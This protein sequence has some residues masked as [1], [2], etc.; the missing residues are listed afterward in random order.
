MAAKDSHGVVVVWVP[1]K[2]IHR[3]ESGD[4]I[5]TMKAEGWELF[6]NR[7]VAEEAS[8]NLCGKCFYHELKQR[9][10]A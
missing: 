9:A 5:S 10:T 8:Y 1:T 3:P 4:G 2:V 6:P 7:H